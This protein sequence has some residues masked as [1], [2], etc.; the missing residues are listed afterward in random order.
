MNISI[1]RQSPT[2]KDPVPPP[3]W[4]QLDSAL[5]LL[6]H[7]VF[8]CLLSVPSVSLSFSISCPL[9]L[10]CVLPHLPQVLNNPLF[11][12]KKKSSHLDFH[13][14]SNLGIVVQQYWLT[15]WFLHFVTQNR[16]HFLWIFP[17]FVRSYQKSL[18]ISHCIS[19]SRFVLPPPSICLAFIAV[20]YSCQQ[21]IVIVD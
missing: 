7:L 9:S 20:L 12:A 15:L 8:P 16:A 14:E 17:L 18:S 5:S 6:C 1:G 11:L 10:S 2:R 21:S 3:L 4:T 19:L 13:L